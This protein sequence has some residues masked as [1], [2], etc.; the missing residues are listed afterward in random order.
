MMYETIMHAVCRIHGMLGH[1]DHD[2]NPAA[3]AGSS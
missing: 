1:D 3:P 2:V